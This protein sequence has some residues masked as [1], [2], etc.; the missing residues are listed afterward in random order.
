MAALRQ[1]S[2]P[3]LALH[4]EPGA[5]LPPG[6]RDGDGLGLGLG[7]A[8]GLE[9]GLALRLGAADSLGVVWPEDEGDDVDAAGKARRDAPRER[10]DDDDDGEE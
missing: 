6:E 5:V 10:F 1:A 7:L 8:P 9:V 3:K 4:T 2:S